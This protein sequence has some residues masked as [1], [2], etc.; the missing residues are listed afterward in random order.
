MTLPS[1]ARP[2]TAK[3]TGPPASMPRMHTASAT[4]A[5]KPTRPPGLCW[6]SSSL[7]QAGRVLSYLITGHR[8]GLHDWH[9]GLEARLDGDDGRSELQPKPGRG[10]SADILS[11]AGGATDLRDIPGDKD[12]FALW[13]RRLFSRLLDANFLD[14]KAFMD[15]PR[16]AGAAIGLIWSSWASASSP[17]WPTWTDRPRQPPSSRCAGRS[18]TN[19]EGPPPSAPASSR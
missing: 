17:A 8:A 13:V 4:P 10:A 5:N 7:A 1:T 18:A 2:S 11:R 14:S 12:G 16:P 19:V 15:P 3:S 9:G 6:Y